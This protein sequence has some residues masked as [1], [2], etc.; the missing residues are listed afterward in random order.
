MRRALL[1]CSLVLLLP[2]AA[3][4][5]DPL[6]GYSI[7]ANAVTQV[8]NTPPGQRVERDVRNLLPLAN[9]GSFVEFVSTRVTL[10]DLL[11]TVDAARLNKIVAA[12]PGV[13]GTALVSRVAVPAVLGAAIE[14]GNI[15]QQTSGTVTTLRGNV[16]GVARLAFGER[17]FPQCVEL[18]AGECRPTVRALRR[19][20]ASVS[21][22]QTGAAENAT[23]DAPAPT[24]LLGDEYRV[25][26]WSARFDLTPSNNLDDPKYVAAWRMA[27][28][29]LQKSGAATALTEA[30]EATFGSDPASAAY[31]A[32][33]AQT[34]PL[35]MKAPAAD[36]RGVLAERLSMLVDTL[37]EA[38]P[39]FGANVRA[40]S[41]A[42]ANYF[43]VRDGLIRDAQ[44]NKFS[45]EYADHRPASEPH[46]ATLRLIYSHQPTS[47]PAIITAN[48]AMTFNSNEPAG[49]ARGS[50]RDVQVAAE[51]DRRLG[52][53]TSFGPVVLTLAAYFQ[54]LKEDALIQPAATA[55]FALPGTRGSIG[56]VQAKL[57]IPAGE[58]VKIPLSVTWASRTE[59]VKEKD[60]RGQ[61]GFTLDV[62]QLFH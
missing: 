22:E 30:V 31:T 12:S 13:G 1:L 4:A 56:V 57:A 58:A 59:L 19:F 20:S 2:R 27:M 32:W 45:L 35:L 28:A 54:W 21:F 25:A 24:A 37:N 49:S 53:L 5:Q 18:T 6:T 61:V 15:L 47:A 51:I 8:A 43:E 40:L 36:F 46:F 9:T 50:V 7:D 11:G 60:V 29:N 38:D 23:G 55:V 26:G 3:A 44:S 33:V 17:Q 34:L 42:Y 52:R 48:A 14:Y 10:A 41:R 39:E 16:L 62:D